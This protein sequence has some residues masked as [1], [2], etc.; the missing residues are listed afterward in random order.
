[1]MISPIIK[2]HIWPYN[3]SQVI[4]AGKASNHVLREIF[5][6]CATVRLRHYF[7]G[8]D[9]VFGDQREGRATASEATEKAI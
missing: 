8:E 1:M 6:G 9:L 4:E 5:I 2:C 3:L 7:E